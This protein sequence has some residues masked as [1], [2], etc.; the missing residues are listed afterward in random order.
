MESY[1]FGL[2]WIDDGE[3]YPFVNNLKSECNLRGLHF[4]IVDENSIG[5]VS[6]DIEK[7]KM[8]IRFFLDLASEMTDSEN[9]FTKFAYRLKDSGS[10]VV[11]DPDRVRS[12]ADKSVTHYSLLDA[13]IDVPY[14]LVIRNWEPTRRLND[15]EKRELKLPFIVKPASGYGQKGVKV[16]KSWM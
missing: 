8:M 11:A 2:G 10:R 16:I 9:I 12:G 1:D 14:T 4:I 15:I 7:D 13:G 3:G 5:A 6:E